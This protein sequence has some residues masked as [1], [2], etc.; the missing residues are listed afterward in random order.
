VGIGFGVIARKIS[1]EI[2]DWVGIISEAR[3]DDNRHGLLFTPAGD[4]SVPLDEER[5]ILIKTDGNGKYIVIGTLTPS[6]GA[7][8]GE[9]ILFSRD[10][11]KA[12]EASVVAKIS[13]LNNGSITIDNDTETTGDATGEY[14]RVTKGETSI[15]ERK[16]RTYLNEKNVTSSIKGNY[17]INVDGNINQTTKKDFSVNADNNAD[18]E[19]KNKATFK[20]KDVE[21]NGDVEATGGSFTC[22][23]I[24]KP[25][26]TGCLCAQPFCLYSGAPITGYRA[27]GT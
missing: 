7:N 17:E 25:S 5:L 4:D 2:K 11:K 15:T 14:K 6:Q 19:A 9:K 21:L 8:P 12:P 1:E 20:A 26:G 24:A 10:W 23:G 22:K 16:D 13:M 18:V 27:D 3:K